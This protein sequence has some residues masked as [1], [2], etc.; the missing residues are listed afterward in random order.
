M[1]KRMIAD[2]RVGE[3]VEDT[4]LLAASELRTTRNGSLYLDLTLA[5]SSGSIKARM[6]D[7]SE[8]LHQAL[9]VDDFVRVK[10]R[11]GMFRNERQFIVNVIAKADSEQI[12][13]RDFLPQST[14]PPEE[15]RKELEDLLRSTVEEPDYRRLIEA[16]LTDDAFMEIFCTAPAAVSYHHSFLSG[17][18]AHTLSMARCAALLCSHYRILRPDLLLASVFVHDIGK[19]RE[20][21]W[22]RTFQYTD[23]GQLVGHIV[24]G[25]VMIEER[26]ATLDDFPPR[27]LNLLRHTII[28]HHGAAE[29]GSPKL[30]MIPEAFAL[31]YIDNIDAKLQDFADAMAD[32]TNPNSDW[33]GY[34]P[35]LG[36]R[37]YKK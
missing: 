29:F 18:L 31:H 26:A 2:V 20:L 35:R 6:W 3:P 12:D 1:A 17:L 30:P 37:L 8:A 7:A 14:R 5:D 4:F 34:I 10:G 9:A 23:T 13:L 24:E 36:R 25:V 21:S 28:A 11:L 19:T 16:F 27:K 22:E 33:T 15:M 32:D